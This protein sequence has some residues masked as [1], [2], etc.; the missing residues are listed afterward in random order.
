M[1]LELDNV[2][3]YFGQKCILSGVYLNAKTGTVTGILGRN[4]SGKSCIL[5]IIFGSLKPKYKLVRL[6]K[7]PILK[8]LYETKQVSLLPQYNFTPNTLKINTLFKLLKV[9]WAIFTNDFPELAKYQHFKIK[10]LSG[11]ERRIIEIY[12]TLKGPTS[13]VLLDEPFNGIA[14]LAIESIKN[15]ITQEKQHKIIIVTDHRYDA[16]LEVS[17]TLYLIKNSCSKLIKNLTELEDY[18]YLSQGTLK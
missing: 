2:A 9:N 5:K 14:P 18:Q 7:K 1:V 15:L 6:N 3:L 10:Q 17:D 13:I 12:L 4:G 8:P 11:G 16:V